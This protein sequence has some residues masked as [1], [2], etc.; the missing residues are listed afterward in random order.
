MNYTIKKKN[1]TLSYKRTTINPLKLFQKIKEE[2]LQ[3]HF[4]RLH[5]LTISK[6]DKN[7]IRKENHSPISW[8]QYTMTEGDL[9]LKYRDSLIHENQWNTH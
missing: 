6:L 1:K 5:Y 2:H 8:S 9:F 7:T 4:K 3:T